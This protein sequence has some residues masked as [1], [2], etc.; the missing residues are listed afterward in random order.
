M[1]RYVKAIVAAI[2][3]GVGAVGVAL[4]DG[5]VTAAEW[6]VIAGAVVTSLGGVWAAPAN[7]PAALADGSEGK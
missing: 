2:L 5:H 3:A 1:D 7:A 4:A 6:V